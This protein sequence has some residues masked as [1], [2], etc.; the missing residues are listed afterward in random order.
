MKKFC[1][2]N[3]LKLD[4]TSNRAQKTTIIKQIEG[5]HQKLVIRASTIRALTSEPIHRR[6]VKLTRRGVPLVKFSETK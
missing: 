1:L 3:K 5:E 6:N 4:K 2:L